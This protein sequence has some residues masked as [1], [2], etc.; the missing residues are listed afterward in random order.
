MKPLDGFGRFKGCPGFT[1]PLLLPINT[2]T[3]LL[4]IYIHSSSICT[5]SIL[6]VHYKVRSHTYSNI[7]SLHNPSKLQKI[8]QN[9]RF[10]T[11][12]VSAQA[13][14]F[15]ALVMTVAEMSNG[16]DN[17][18][19]FYFK[20]VKHLC[21]TGITEVPDKYILPVSDRP[22]VINEEDA[23]SIDDLNLK[24]PIIDFAELHGP[25]RSRVL[26]SLNSACANH[27][28]FQVHYT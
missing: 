7:Y 14:M 15:P 27:G 28:F 3:H 2:R 13:Y 26:E 23:T 25:N 18:E 11:E 24:L 1:W 22:R 9:K 16:S 19:D 4:T 12:K 17:E 8:E 20:G 5:Y 21:E 10:E 6:C